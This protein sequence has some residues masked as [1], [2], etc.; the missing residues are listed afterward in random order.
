M[1]DFIADN[2]HLVAI[3]PDGVISSQWFGTDAQAAQDW[4]APRI[5]MDNLY[6]TVNTT[7]KHGKPTKADI[8]AARFAHVD[9]DPPDTGEWD[10]DAALAA[11]LSQRPT[12]VIDSGNGFQGLWRLNRD[13]P[14]VETIN[15][16]IAAALGADSRVWN[17]DRLFRVPGTIN[18]PNATKLAKGRTEQ[19]TA[20]LHYDPALTYDPDVLLQ[21]YPAPERTTRTSTQDVQLGEWSVYDPPLPSDPLRDLLWD[22]VAAGG[23][24]EHAARLAHHMGREGY[25]LEQIMGTLMNPV[26]PWSGTIHEQKDPERQARRKLGGVVV[27]PRG[28]EMFPD[29]LPLPA[30][31][32]PP[33]RKRARAAGYGKRSQGMFMGISEQLEHFKGC[34]YITHSD[35]VLIPDGSELNQSRFDVMKGGHLFAID[36]IND[37]STKSAWEAFLKNNAYS[38]PTVHNVCFRPELEP[39]AVVQDGTY[40]LVNTYQPIDT[41]CAE[42]DASPFT[43][44]FAKLFPDERDQRIL[45]SYMASLVRNPG[46]K[47]QWWPVIQGAKGNGKT[48][49]LSILAHCVG[50][51]YSHLPNTSKMTRNGISFNG[52]L[53]GKLFIGMDEVYSSQRRDFLEEFKPYVTNRRLPIESKGVD[54]YTGDNRAN[55]MML[56]NHK[57]GV[58]IDKDERR[59]AVFFTAQQT[60]DDCFKDGMTP[61]YFSKLWR[62]LDNE[63]LAILNN[64][65]RNYPIAEEFDPAGLASRA[66]IT[67]STA[68]A[69][70][71]SRG[72]AETEVLDA[73]DSE[74]MG[75][76]GGFVSSRMVAKLMEEKRINLPRNKYKEML[77]SLGYVPHP[78]LPEG[79]T[80]SPVLPDGART[81]LYVLRDTDPG[82][83]DVYVEKQ[84]AP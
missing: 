70:E 4:L 30:T 33:V 65:L 39:F 73:I 12:V 63:G 77:G 52:W 62:W 21:H 3:R 61:R 56:T 74:R 23:R 55:G 25:T 82:G 37:K 49:L 7:T 24:S 19:L 72:R 22:D 59:Y 18:I 31:V 51:Q 81:I 48:M 14:H 28:E 69:I 38:P 58:P 64:Y 20:L 10:R 79:K 60:A 67:S 5:G 78:S 16:G 54:E 41:P 9:I 75:F 53:K 13:T 42:G 46:V 17:I 68:H 40:K 11:L 6:F 1:L 47:F 34:V 43:D 83:A 27:R 29:D 71:A 66:P 45:L 57:D 84:M 2:I 50:D 26:W 15:Q 32:E 36:D 8:S 44:H 35:R 80:P 76:R